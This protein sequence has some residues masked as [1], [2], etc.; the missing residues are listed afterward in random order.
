MTIQIGEKV[1]VPLHKVTLHSPDKYVY[2]E[3]TYLERDG[4]VAHIRLTQAYMGHKTVT[5]MF[6][7]LKR[8]STYEEL[9]YFDNPPPVPKCIHIWKESG[10]GIHMKTGEYW[11]NCMY[12][13]VAKEKV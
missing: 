12:C 10:Q 1:K 7:T 9:T 13:G 11:Y 8:V 4:A 5:A 2:G 3:L 6:Y